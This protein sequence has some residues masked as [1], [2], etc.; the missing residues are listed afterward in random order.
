MVNIYTVAFLCAFVL[1][2]LKEEQQKRSQLRKQHAANCPK[3]PLHYW[4]NYCH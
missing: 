1:E 4:R 3:K 2:I